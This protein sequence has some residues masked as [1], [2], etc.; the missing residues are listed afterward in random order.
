MHSATV[1][2]VSPPLH[3][4]DPLTADEISH[5]VAIVRKTQALA[6]DT[7][8]VRVSLHEPSKEIVLGFREGEA[9]NP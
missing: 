8:F 5:A 6:D 4:L 9:L 2:H 3:P 7:L 1:S